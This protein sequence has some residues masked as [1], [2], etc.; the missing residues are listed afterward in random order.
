ML[1]AVDVVVVLLVVL[2]P[3]A[4]LVVEPVLAP[5]LGLE[6]ALGR[7]PV[8]EPV[9]L[10]AGLIVEPVELAE[11]AQ[12]VERLVPFD[13]RLRQVEQVDRLESVD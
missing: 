8:A 3:A 9:A 6:P 10:A 1:D 5:E 11:P 13:H 7:E 2:E 12:F 4:E